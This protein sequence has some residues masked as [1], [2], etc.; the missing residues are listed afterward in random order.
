MAANK[1]PEFDIPMAA[2]WTYTRSSH[3]DWAGGAER[4]G[5]PAAVMPLGSRLFSRAGAGHP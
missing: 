3:G 4:Y 2:R 1:R 5:L